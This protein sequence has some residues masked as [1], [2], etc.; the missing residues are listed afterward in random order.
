MKFGINK[1]KEQPLGYWEEK[2]YMLVVSE[3]PTKELLETIF[4]R[5]ADIEGVKVKEKHNL[6]ALEP[7][8]MLLSYEGD[9]YEVGFYPSD[10]TF[11]ELYIN[12]NYCFS[13][14][15]IEKLRTANTALTI[16]MKFSDNPKKSYH[17]QLKLACAMIPDM[18]GVLDESSEKMLPVAWVKMTAFS[19]VLPSANDLFTVQ[20]VTSENGEVWLHTHGLCRCDITELEVLQSNKDI[21]NSHYNLITTFAS[22][23]IDKKKNY[24]GS[25]CIG[26][27]SNRQPVVVTYLSWTKALGEYKHLTLGNSKDRKRGHNSKT[28]VIFLYKSEDDEKKGKISKVSCF[29]NL[30]EDNPIFF[31]SNEET[32]R[33]KALAMERFDYVKD[34]IKNKEN[35]IIIKIGLPVDNGQEND[36]EHI[37]FELSCFKDKKFKA[38]LLQEPYNVSNIKVGDERWFTVSDVTDWVIYTPTFPVVPG[39]VYVLNKE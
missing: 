38:K 7:G 36:F 14:E 24:D 25:L 8:T 27:L 22:Y 1:L 39:N 12:K 13:N 32:A 23:L 17:L 37:W 4:E 28:S 21:Y 2:S 5:V 19:K 16:F 10:F 20:A 30:W 11:A 33:M 26:L 35:R 29:D 31:I 18:L 15:E 34:A 6:T 9:N 3:N